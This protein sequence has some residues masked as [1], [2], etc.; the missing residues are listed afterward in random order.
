MGAVV[1]FPVSVADVE[2]GA[3]VSL[4]LMVRNTGTVVD[5]FD[6]EILGAADA[7]SRFE[8]PTVSLFPQGEE[9]V[10]VTFS[11]PRAANTTSGSVPF[12]V[13]VQSREDPEGTVVEE[14]L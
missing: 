5:R 8:P 7:W 6:F 1:R 11:P 4:E 9:T 3:S 13:R 2:P 14:G 12:G 10:K